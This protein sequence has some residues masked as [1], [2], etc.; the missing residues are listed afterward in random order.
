MILPLQAGA[1]FTVPFPYV[2]NE[3]DRRD[4]VDDWPW[5]PGIRTE[6]LPP[7]GADDPVA[8]AMG[9][10]VLTVVSTHK[11]GKYQERVFYTRKWIDPDGTTFGKG[12]LKVTTTG[13]FR[14]LTSGYSLPFRLKK[15]VA[16]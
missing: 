7:E 9:Q 14:K 2:R 10:M 3:Y 1:V 13:C 4:R 11:P 6:M 8:D 15:E 16:A 5:K 12:L